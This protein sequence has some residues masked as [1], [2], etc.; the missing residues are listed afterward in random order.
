MKNLMNDSLLVYEEYSHRTKRV[1]MDF[2]AEFFVR[3]LCAEYPDAVL[4][5]IYRVF[6]GSSR[7]RQRL[8]R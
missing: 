3:K 4:D 1:N 5:D 2:L 6:C 8:T 7:A